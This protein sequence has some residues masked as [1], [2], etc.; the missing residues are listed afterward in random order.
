MS[1]IALYITKRR[2]Y[3]PEEKV[4]IAVEV[5]SR[6]LKRELHNSN[7]WRRCSE[8]YPYI[9]NAS[10]T[11]WRA[12]LLLVHDHRQTHDEKHLKCSALGDVFLPVG[13]NGGV[14]NISYNQFLETYDGICIS[15]K[16]EL[17]RFMIMIP[18]NFPEE[19]RERPS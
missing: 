13:W 19:T 18:P 1:W 6:M 9:R 14:S 11:L 10:H 8:A 7:K 15:I 17:K 5:H 3:I 4:K 2:V 12:V 16:D